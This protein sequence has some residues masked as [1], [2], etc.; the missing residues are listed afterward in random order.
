[1]QY[2]LR[3]VTYAAEQRTKEIGIRK[4]LSARVSGIA[5]LLS[6]DFTMLVGIVALIAFPGTK[7]TPNITAKGNSYSEYRRLC[8]RLLGDRQGYIG[9]FDRG[10]GSGAVFGLDQVKMPSRVHQGAVDFLV[11]RRVSGEAGFC[12]SC[13]GPSL[14]R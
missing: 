4:V 11:D 10:G 1:M 7:L 9:G 2:I 5:G 6:K 13:L 3:R 14:P 8:F 12:P